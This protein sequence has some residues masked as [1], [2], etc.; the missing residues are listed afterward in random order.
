MSWNYRILAHQSEEEIHL[1]V[2]EVYYNDEGQP[3]GYTENGVAV[4]AEDLKGIEWVLDKMKECSEKPILWAGD[5]FPHE[6]K[7]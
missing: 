3:N 6:Y 4:G 5:K 1:Q 7:N 2:H